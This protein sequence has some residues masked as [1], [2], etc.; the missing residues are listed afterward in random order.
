MGCSSIKKCRV[1]SSSKVETILPLGE[2]PP[3]NALKEKQNEEEEKFS[4]T[5]A[6]CEDCSLVQ[7]L[8]T[9]DK[10]ALFD[11]YFWVTGTSSTARAF[12]DEFKDIIEEIAKPTNE[13]LILEVA[14][15]DGT[16]LKPFI[17]SGRRVLGIDPARNIVEMANKDNVNTF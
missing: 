7:I 10:E 1:C 3:A 15:N 2:H 8:E 14:S 4:L 12:A 6:F 11:Q 9:V 16:F 13:D 5:L 17:K